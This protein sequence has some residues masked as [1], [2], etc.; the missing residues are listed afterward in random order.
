MIAGTFD[1]GGHSISGLYWK[2]AANGIGFIR[3]MGKGAIV[4]NFK[5]LNSYFETNNVEVNNQT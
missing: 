4:R 1:G 5:L 3:A 2:E